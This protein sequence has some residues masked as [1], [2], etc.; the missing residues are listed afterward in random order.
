MFEVQYG[1]GR[2]KFYLSWCIIKKKNDRS[3]HIIIESASQREENYHQTFLKKDAIDD[4][5][6]KHSSN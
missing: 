2:K 4:K 3:F 1:K 6:S 5:M